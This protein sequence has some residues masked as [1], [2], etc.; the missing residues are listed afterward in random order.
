[1][2]KRVR[3]KGTTGAAAPRWPTLAERIMAASGFLMLA[4]AAALA[5][6]VEPP[7]ER[8]KDDGPPAERPQDISGRGWG[9]I[10][11]STW[12]EFNQDQIPQVAGGVAFFTILSLFPA[13]AAFVS[14]YGLFAD[15]SKVSEHLVML[16]GFLPPSALR[17]VAGE[18]DRL[19]NGGHSSLG[20]AF[21][22]SLLA[23]L[24]SAN[25][26]VKA[27][28]VGLNTAYEVTERRGLIRLNLVSLAFTVGALA[29]VLAS[30]GLVV[31]GPGVLAWIGFQHG[32]DPTLLSVMR[33]PALLAVASVGLALL[34][35][36]GPSRGAQR[37]RWI[38]P[39]SVLAAAGW[40]LSSLLFSGYVASF[41]HYEKTYGSLG[42]V[43][44]FMIWLW[45]TIVVVLAGAELNSEVEDEAG[46]PDPPD[47]RR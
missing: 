19:A 44:A 5:A 27:L 41:G 43:M 10:A 31:L 40:M 36:Y 8:P 13:M 17:F 11:A 42:A 18:M 47:P 23:S 33:W 26:A 4:A 20:L 6:R 32:I 45:I 39:G 2:A 1:M 25:G 29:F 12:S 28:F 22:V 38:T 3:P 35:R 37:W 14:L 16:A 34:Y 46:A 9:R 21:A 15:P 7:A 24:W 30:L